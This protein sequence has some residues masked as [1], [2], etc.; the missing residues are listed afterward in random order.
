MT[1]N[2]GTFPQNPDFFVFYSNFVQ[3]Q[4]IAPCNHSLA[5]DVSKDR[6]SVSI[7][8]FFLFFVF[9]FFFVNY[10]D[11]SKIRDGDDANRRDKIFQTQTGKKWFSMP[12]ITFL[13][14]FDKLKY[15]IR[16]N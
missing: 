2:K 16:I 4:V 12:T 8:I 6:G 7:L 3:N 9:C 5:R 1:L 11:T 13:N 15:L 10:N 14:R